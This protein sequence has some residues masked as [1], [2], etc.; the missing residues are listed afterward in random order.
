MEAILLWLFKYL[1]PVLG[2]VGLVIA[3][4]TYRSLLAKPSGNEKMQEIAEAIRNGATAFLKQEFTTLVFVIAIAFLLIWWSLG[5]ESGI[6]F[7]FGASSSLL[8]GFMGMRA[9]TSANVRTAQAAADNNAAEALDISF[10]GGSVMGLSVACLGVLGLGVLFWFFGEPKIF[11]PIIGFGMGA[12]LV[13]LFARVG[14][15]IYTKAAD[16]GADLV[17]K[18]EANIPEDDPRNPGVIAD[19]VG[20]NVG[21]VAGMG[22]DIYESYVTCLIGA[23]ALGATANVAYLTSHTAF[24]ATTP[25]HLVTNYRVWL[26]LTPV[27]LGVLG[28]VGSYVGILSIKLFK[29]GEPDL[30]LR[31]TT[32]VASLAFLALAFVYFVIAPV[33]LELWLCAV[34]G[35]ACGIAIGL[36]TEYFTGSKPVYAIVEGAKTGP[37]TCII[38]GMATGFQSCALPV[39]IIALAVFLSDSLGGFYG[40]AISGVA[41]LATVCMTMTI[42]AF[43]PIADNAGGIAEMAHLG[44]ETRAITDKLDVLGNT[45]AAI[46]KGFAIGAAG[47]AALSIFGAYVE[48]LGVKHTQLNLSITN[49]NLIVGAFIG[50]ILPGLVSAYTMRAVGRAAGMMVTEIRRQF[51]EIEGLLEGKEGIKPDVQKCVQISTKAALSEMIKPGIVAV[52]TPLLVGFILGP[53]AL[54][55][56]L[57]GTT[58]TGVILGMF[59]SNTGG[60]WDNAKKFIEQGKVEGEK[61]GSD[62]HKAAV[63]GD[64]VG[65]PFKDTSGP[66][67]N[68]LIKMVSML[69]LLIAPLL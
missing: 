68:I 35:V 64:T 66:S 13:A 9:A 53:E 3:Y 58:I 6:C 31:K 17:G 67:L 55:G 10:N 33:D 25:E 65:D 49:S 48:A 62:A 50:A 22:A 27:V 52:V 61:K 59:M 18:V 2:V 14:G 1:S 51:R 40:V 38:A 42:D 23:I 41:M 16:V 29:A 24:D 60:A 28:L 8:A 47:V 30:A 63:V 19:N 69:A 57:L 4:Q 44:S 32:L 34:S 11:E 20:D 5:F 26:M 45:T 56:L 21:D 12:S 39:V 37:A 43:G 36:I 15:G 54:G 46:G 7:V